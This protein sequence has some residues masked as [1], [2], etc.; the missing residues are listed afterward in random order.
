[1]KTISSFNSW[2]ICPRPNSQAKL[3]LFCFHY[4]GGGA[5]AFRP[6]PNSLPS[7]V[8]IC[9][10][11]LPGREMR[12]ME[13]PF[14]NI[15][16]LLKALEKAIFPYL[17]KPF[18]F[19]GHSMGALVSFELA[20]LLRQNHGLSPLQL[21]VSGYHAPQVLDKDPPIHG[22]PESEFLEE[23]RSYNG[24]PEEVFNNTEFME[25]FLPTLRADFA[26]LE[27]YIYS[28]HPPLN[29]PITALGG[30]QDKKCSLD[31][32]EAWQEQTN[33]QFSLRMFPGDH[34]FLNSYRDILLDYLTQQL[35]QII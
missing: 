30:L 23:L 34:F 22:L 10:V 4:A 35:K 6:W 33:N 13:A 20:Q 26:I 21:F 27:N 19:F 24:T 2:I 14:N 5:F 11:T 29:C 28:P 18:A 3:R 7:N 25:L 9:A 12:L 8:E 31:D 17:D 1:M 16:P 32:L 15:Q